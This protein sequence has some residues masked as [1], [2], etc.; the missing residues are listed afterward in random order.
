MT[1]PLIK[2][3]IDAWEI[4]GPHPKWHR[5]CKNRLFDEWRTLY[6]AIKNLVDHE[7]DN[8]Y[9]ETLPVLNMIDGFSWCI[10]HNSLRVDSRCDY[11]GVSKDIPCKLHPL[12]YMDDVKII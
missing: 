4:P 3:L 9:I 8:G 2:K 10:T 12:M 1:N 5:K 6:D 7:I 11:S